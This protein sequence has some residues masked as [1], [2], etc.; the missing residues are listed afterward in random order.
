MQQ[1]LK[2]EVVNVTGCV[3]MNNVGPSVWKKKRPAHQNELW[4]FSF[5]H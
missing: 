5:L 3:L 1:M 2:M 4:Y